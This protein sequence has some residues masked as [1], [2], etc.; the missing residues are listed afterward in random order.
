MD[1]LR[2]LAAFAKPDNAASVA[3]ALPPSCVQDLRGEP[4]TGRGSARELRPWSQIVGLTFHQT[5][6]GNLHAAHRALLS[7][8]AH[9]IVHRDGTWSWLHPFERVVW[10]GHALNRGTIGIEIDCRA[11]GTEGDPRTFWRSRKEQAAGKTY[12]QLVREATPAQ[13]TAIPTVM[14]F[15]VDT[16]AANGGAVR[17]NWAH[18]QG[19][20]SRT[21]DPGSRVWRAVMHAGS[22]LDLVDVQ[23]KTLGSGNP[24]PAAWR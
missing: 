24:I 11:A 9:I 19:H 13:L 5:A 18:R 14:R 22:A 4:R 6:S 10:H 2:L 8:P 12:E 21:S 23:D 1:L 7:I 20:S 16:V 15:C 17:A 3:P